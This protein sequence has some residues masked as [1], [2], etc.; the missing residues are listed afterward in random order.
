MS[1]PCMPCGRAVGISIVLLVSVMLVPM[2]ARAYFD[3]VGYTRLVNELAAAG[4][5]VPDGE[6]VI[7]CHEEMYISPDNPNFANKTMHW[8]WGQ[9]YELWPSGVDEGTRQHADGTASLFFGEIDSMAPG[10]R[11]L[12]KYTHMWDNRPWLSS[13]TRVSTGSD[14]WAPQPSICDDSREYNTL[15][16]GYT[17]RQIDWNDVIRTRIVTNYMY[18]RGAGLAGSAYNVITVGRSDA[19]HSW[20]Y[21]T[22]ALGLYTSPRAVIDIVTP[23][24]FTS[25][26]NPIAASAATMLVD[27]SMRNPDLSNGSYENP[28]TGGHRNHAETPEAIK[29][30]I[31]AGADR[32]FDNLLDYYDPGAYAPEGVRPENNIS[33][34]HGAGQL[35]VYNS[36]HI[37]D[38]G[39]YECLENQTETNNRGRIGRW[40]FDYEPAFTESSVATY[41]FTANGTEMTATLTWHVNCE[42]EFEGQY[43]F[44]TLVDAKLY[45]LDLLLYD[46]TDP[47]SPVLHAQSTSTTENTENLAL[48]GMDPLQP[49]LVPGHEYRLV[50]QPKPGQDPFMWDYALAWQ[51]D[52]VAAPRFIP[53]PASLTLLGMA[54]LVL[55]FRRERTC[56]PSA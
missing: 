12:D 43:W 19:Q 4:K 33:V 7:V 10:T 26:A 24:P 8:Y 39:E 54:E 20:Y 32:I 49:V 36:Y 40:G 28:R 46:I 34:R 1:F 6:N 18:T 38:S 42:N 29:A 35:N 21:V 37:M 41:E 25:Q 16:M 14:L 52:A 55:A 31:M 22:D 48:L 56:L 50:V 3:E 53:E 27:H 13:D 5:I 51:I 9:P 2:P 23:G 30:I 15:G 44:G 47:Q 17:D 45:D 11:L